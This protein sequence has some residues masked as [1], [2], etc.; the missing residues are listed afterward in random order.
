VAMAKSR[1]ERYHRTEDM[2]EDLQ[3]V[4]RGEP[5]Q[6]AR[7]GVNLEEWEKVETSG[8]TIDINEPPP[9]PELWSHPVVIGLMAAV[10]VCVIMILVL[11]VMVLTKASVLACGV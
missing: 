8:K 9:P 6:H 5:P 4:H 1:D 3:A 11:V 2:L 10:G 7:R